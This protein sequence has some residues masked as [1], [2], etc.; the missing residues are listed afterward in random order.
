MGI[1][2]VNRL[3]NLELDVKGEGSRAELLLYILLQQTHDQLHLILFN[4]GN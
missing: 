3:V 4:P 1:F 2:I